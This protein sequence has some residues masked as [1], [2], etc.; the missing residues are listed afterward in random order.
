MKQL[1]ELFLLALV[2]EEEAQFDY[3]DRKL[4]HQNFVNIYIYIY[5]YHD[6]YLCKL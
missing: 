2:R 4:F 3:E 6:R 1:A 5:I